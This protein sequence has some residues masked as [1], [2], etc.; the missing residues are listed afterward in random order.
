MKHWMIHTVVFAAAQV[1]FAVIGYSWPWEVLTGNESF[2]TILT[3]ASDSSIPVANP[4]RI[5]TIVWLVDTVWTLV[6]GS[7]R[8][9]SATEA[10]GG[11]R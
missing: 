10:Q 3:G 6:A 9:P 7:G 5:W 11:A 1:V 4:S 8:R 2:S